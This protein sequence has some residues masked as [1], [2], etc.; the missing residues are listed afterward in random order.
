MTSEAFKRQFEAL[1]ADYRRRLPEKFAKLDNLW[2]A[3]K[4]GSL[5]PARLV[6]LQRE[7]HS[8]VG[9]AKTL[10]VPAVTESARIA[11]SFIEPFSAQGMIPGAAE[12]IEFERLLDALKLSAAEP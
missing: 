6:D 3:L 4:S 10:G 9:T 5:A 11:E 2:H 1:S 7:L 8:L 12:Q